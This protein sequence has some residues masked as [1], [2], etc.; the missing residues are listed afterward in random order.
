MKKSMFM[1]TLIFLIKVN[2]TT[3]NITDILTFNGS[4]VV[5][6]YCLEFYKYPYTKDTYYYLVAYEKNDKGF[7]NKNIDYK[8]IT[9]KPTLKQTLKKLKDQLCNKRR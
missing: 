6:N 2:A 4:V 7:Y 3:V 1:L 5:N 8:S 9:K